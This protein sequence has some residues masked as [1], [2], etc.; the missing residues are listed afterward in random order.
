MAMMVAMMQC[1]ASMMGD[2]KILLNSNSLHNGLIFIPDSDS[3]CQ[4]QPFD[5]LQIIGVGN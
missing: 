3:L 4:T 1:P 2:T 5:H